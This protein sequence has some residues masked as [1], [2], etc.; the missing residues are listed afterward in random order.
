MGGQPSLGYDV[1][2]RKLV[3]NEAEAA[4]VRY[5]YFGAILNLGR[6]APCGMISPPL[7]SSANT[8]LRRMVAPMAANGFRAGRF[9]SC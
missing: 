1:K 7:A 6:C 9:T 2:E 3:V 5:I 4:T 8:A